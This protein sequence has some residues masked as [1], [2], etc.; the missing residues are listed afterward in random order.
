MASEKHSKGGRIYQRGRRWYAG[1]YVA[2]VEKIRPGG[3]KYEA[4]KVLKELQRERDEGRD[5]VPLEAILTAYGRNVA[6][7]R[8]RNTLRSFREG[9]RILLEYFGRGFCTNDLTMEKLNK[10]LADRKKTRAPI[11]ANKPCKVLRAA[12]HYAVA[13][14]IL[15]GMPCKIPMLT[16]TKRKPRILTVRKFQKIR[17]ACEHEGAQ[18]AIILAYQAGLRHDEIVHLRVR[19]IQYNG[20]DDTFTVEVRAHDGWTPKSHA[21]RSVLLPETA[22]VAV[23]SHLAKHKFAEDRDAP[24][25]YWGAR[26]PHRY[27][28]LYVPV[29]EAFKRA[30]IYSKADKSGLHMCRRSFASHLLSGGTDLKTVMEMGGW[31]SIEAVQRYLASTTELKRRAAAILEVD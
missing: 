5:Y 13:D 18:L 9:E 16:E 23:R 11:T 10:L 7:R 24:L 21:E 8:K 28:D 19:D 12:L 29:R 4:L 17:D 1:C 25:I 22:H 20:D 27:L 3:T 26:K 2:G 15:K 31:S 30:G 14:N 6:A